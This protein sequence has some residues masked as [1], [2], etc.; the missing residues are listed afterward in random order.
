MTSLY[1]PGM[2]TRSGFIFFI[3]IFPG[4]VFSQVHKGRVLSTE[5]NS[6]IGFVNVGIIGRNVGTVTD[7]SGNFTIPLENIYNN[8]SL[9]FSMIGYESKTFLVS[10]FRKDTIRNVYMKPVSYTLQEVK[11]VYRKPKK[12]TLGDPVTSDELRSGFGYNDLGSELG[13]KVHTRGTVKLEDIHLNVAI[14]TFDTVTYRLNIYQIVNKSEYRNILTNP[15]Y[16]SFSKDKID[17]PVTLDISKYNITIEGDVLITLE[18]FKDLGQGQ[19]LF[20]TA[21]FTGITYHKKTSEGKWT[22]SPGVIGMYLH[23]LIIR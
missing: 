1:F 18:L 23:G 10:R 15:V 12:T 14:C 21:F 4:L 19:L 3:L 13:I 20:R 11:V 6:G 7:N 16:M 8:D 9:R 5:N 2:K 17:K 22:E